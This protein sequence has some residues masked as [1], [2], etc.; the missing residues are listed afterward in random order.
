MNWLSLKALIDLCLFKKIAQRGNSST[1]KEIHK[2]R[3][4]AEPMLLICTW[5]YPCFVISLIA[6]IETDW[7]GMVTL[8][9]SNHWFNHRFIEIIELTF[10]L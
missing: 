6:F 9:H 8:W 7:G 10:L 2:Q 1:Q 3:L 5:L 4:V